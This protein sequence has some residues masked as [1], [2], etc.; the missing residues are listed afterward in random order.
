DSHSERL[1]RGGSPERRHPAIVRTGGR[2]STGSCGCRLGRRTR[3]AT[4]STAPVLWIDQS[5]LHLLSAPAPHPAAVQSLW[6]GHPRPS[7]RSG[8]T[9]STRYS[10]KMTI[11][12]LLL[13]AT[14]PVTVGGRVG[15]IPL[16]RPLFCGFLKD[17]SGPFVR[18]SDA[19]RNQF[20]RGRFV[21]SASDRA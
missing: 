13:A 19:R 18:R 6:C 1:C 7:V 5:H 16:L 20:H 8:S 21:A 10:H 12:T 2:H 14:T 9:S 4:T 3:G 17:K 15:C 11:R